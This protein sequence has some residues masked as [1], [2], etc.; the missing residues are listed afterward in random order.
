MN[1]DN[2]RCAK[3]GTVNQYTIIVK[4]SQQTCYCAKCG[5]FLGNKPKTEYQIKNLRMSFGQYKD[6]LI[7]EVIDKK[8]LHWVLGNVK[9]STALKQA[10]IE[11]IN[12]LTNRKTQ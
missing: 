10:I 12:Q 6:T 1:W 9:M 2:V 5:K 4:N 11:Q 7:C 8:Y 3:C